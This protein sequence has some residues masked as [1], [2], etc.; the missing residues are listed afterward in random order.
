M[1]W[2]SSIERGLD[3][4]PSHVF[5]HELDPE[6]R[7]DPTFR[8]VALARVAAVAVAH[9]VNPLGNLMPSEM[10]NVAKKREAASGLVFSATFFEQPI[11]EVERWI[12]V[13]QGYAS[14]EWFYV[15]F[16]D[17]VLRPSRRK[18][19]NDNED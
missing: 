19:S 6:L 12:T 14:A 15:L 8:E 5:F 7:D 16:L 2:L 9:A 17:F 10:Q 4:Q 11:D 3:F 1:D 18:V 13:T